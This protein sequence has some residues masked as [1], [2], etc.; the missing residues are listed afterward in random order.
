MDLSED[1]KK[2]ISRFA[3]KWN[4]LG[5]GVPWCDLR[6]ITIYWNLDRVSVQHFEC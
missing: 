2:I 5:G 3:T 1:I 4:L 6:I